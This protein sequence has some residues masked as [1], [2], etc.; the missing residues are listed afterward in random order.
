MHAAGWA[1]TLALCAGAG[2]GVLS[3][4][5]ASAPSA[6]SAA[7]V[8]AVDSYVPDAPVSTT[9]TGNA[10]P[11]G[12]VTVAFGAG[13]FVAAESVSLAL[14]GAGRSTLAAAHAGTITLTK[15]TDAAGSLAVDVTLPPAASGSYTLVATGLK[16]ATVGAATIIVAEYLAVPVAE[17]GEE[18]DE[19]LA[20]T[21]A[22]Q[23]VTA[24][25]IA[26]TG[27]DSAGGT[28]N[29]AIAAAAFTPH[30]DVAFAVVGSG[31]ATLSAV[32]AASVSLVLSA[33]A[34]GAADLTVTLPADAAGV[35]TVSAQ[36]LSSHTRATTTITVGASAA[37]AADVPEQ[38]EAS[39]AVWLRGYTSPLLYIWIATGLSL[40]ALG[41]IGVLRLKRP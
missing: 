9:V 15:V 7:S 8:S 19:A 32:R 12:T 20:D 31:S 6:A 26:V 28:A 39:G 35:Y 22:R 41:M 29:V 1:L 2:A 23:V 40:L 33:D 24:N 10:V 4:A 18:S 14:T 17:A 11:S 34:A 16:S 36:G 13:S 3:L 5:G 21:G 30:E 37:A 25:H 27:D 38:V